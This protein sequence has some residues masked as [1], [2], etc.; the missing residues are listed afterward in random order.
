MVGGAHVL[1]LSKRV[2]V[3]ALGLALLLGVGVPLSAASTIH[4]PAPRTVSW[5]SPAGLIGGVPHSVSTEATHCP[6]VD[7]TA[8]P[9]ARAAMVVA[10][11]SLAQLD[12][13]VHR[14]IGPYEG[15][16]VAI[17]SLCVPAMAISDGAAG[18]AHGLSGVTQLPAP[19]AA[20]ATWD[21]A[22]A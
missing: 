9:A 15:N 19:V 22:E 11:M 10:R 17:P 20:A 8:S 2:L 7:S 4:G 12:D 3:V 13:M 14:V 1:R 21:P 5:A 6:W 16:T 18:V